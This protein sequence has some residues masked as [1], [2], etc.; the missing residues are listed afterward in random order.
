MASELLQLESL[1][2][3]AV[4]LPALLWLWLP[5]HPST[6]P[7]GELRHVSLGVDKFLAAFSHPPVSHPCTRVLE[8]ET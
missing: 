7:L 2:D 4:V 6:T 5:S 8:G 3:A 1:W